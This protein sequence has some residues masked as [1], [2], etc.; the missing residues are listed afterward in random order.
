MEKTNSCLNSQAIIKYVSEKAPGEVERLFTGLD[1]ELAE[2]EDKREF[3][4]DP[5][6]WVSSSVMVRLYENA[7]KILGDENVAYKIGYDSV[8]KRRFG[9]VQKIL[10]YAFG[11]PRNILNYIQKLN[12]KFNKT[13]TIRLHSV[14]NGSAVVHLHW[15]EGMELSR[16]FCQFNQGIY[17]AV[18]TVWG[19]S[20]CVVKETQCYFSGA[21]F[22]EYVLSWEKQSFLKRRLFQIVAPWKIASQSI[23][24]LEKDKEVLQ[25]KYE[26]IHALNKELRTRIEQLSALHETSTAILST[27]DL[28]E[29]LDVLLKR[30]MEVA[31]LER[32][33]V[34]LLDRKMNRLSFIH[35]AGVDENVLQEIK[36]YHIPIGKKNNIIARAAR[37]KRPILVEDVNSISLNRR[38]PL[39]VTFKP[40][41]FVIV[42]LTVRGEV[43]GIMVG[44]NV[45][46]K[47]FI[48]EIDRDFLASF[49]NHIAMAIENANLYQRLETSERKYRQI[50]ENINEGILIMDNNG[51]IE[52]SNRKMNELMGRQS[53]RGIK[54]NEL[55]TEEKDRKKLISIM[56]ANYQGRQAKDELSLRAKNEILVPALM[57]SVPIMD[58]ENGSIKGCLALITDLTQQKELERKLLQAQ[59][60][61]SIGTMAG[62][63][64]H[65]FNN[66]LT[67]ILGFA[68]LMKEKTKDQ[69]DLYRFTEIIEKSSI[70]AAD[71]VKKMLVFSRDA[72][73]KE[74]GSCQPREVADEVVGLIKSS[75]PKDITVTVESDRDLPRIA[76]S[77]GQLQQVL[78]NLCINARDAMPSGGKI[79]IKNDVISNNDLPLALGRRL[80]GD[81]FFC[82]AVSDTGTGMPKEVMDR[83]FDPFFT[84]K[85]VGKGSGLGLAMVYGIMENIGGAIDVKSQV[86]MGTTFYLYF[87]LSETEKEDKDDERFPSNT[88]GGG[89]VLI[90]DDEEMV[91]ALAAETLKPHGYKV[92][93]ARNGKEAISVYRSMHPGIDLVIMDVLMPEMDGI[94][95]AKAIRDFDPQAKILFCSGYTTISD[96]SKS[97]IGSN[98]PQN[99]VLIK[100]PFNPLALVL[101]VG[102]ALSKS[103]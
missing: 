28:T 72:S 1:G 82:I 40:K 87:P 75:F 26:K 76:C 85:E 80:K 92:V 32:A 2:I 64:A 62:G 43:V 23:Q 59:K 44:D 96:V 19:G 90:V 7:K 68:T 99:P 55:V 25:R 38:N 81:R 24:E 30:M 86:G 91:L 27:L 34:F 39:L 45:T 20:S 61:E 31:R 73:S 50:V 49:A 79:V 36:N 83:I 47:D 52:F 98:G 3:L 54:I 29:L 89:T 10:M 97:D 18:P 51:T 17:S 67:G 71:L 58:E 88:N 93:T 35:G 69:P 57:S 41:A 15:H 60:L 101:V 66:I 53:L 94:E 12:D 70:R 48:K 65:D 11:S 74:E 95:A 22:C 84:T 33:G 16:D 5:N 21:P 77:S 103:N 6:N 42:P 4:S 9:Y 8:V 14:E 78:M 102:Q 37:S 63:I 100:K 56:M 46:N 13:K